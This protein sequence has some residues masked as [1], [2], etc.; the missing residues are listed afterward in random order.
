[1]PN[2]S[3]YGFSIE[4]QLPSTGARAADL[5]RTITVSIRNVYGNE[6]IYPACPTSLF[7]CR[8]ARTKT[9]T[10]EMMRLIRAQG[11]DVRVEAPTLKFTGAR[12]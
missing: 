6:T 8:L 5:S 11:I 10:E 7:F 3:D 9:I 4:G 12:S 2:A 1:M